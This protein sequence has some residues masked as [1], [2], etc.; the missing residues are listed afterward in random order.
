[1]LLPQAGFVI[2]ATFVENG[3]WLR[4][5]I[6]TRCEMTTSATRH[7]RNTSSGRC[8]SSRCRDWSRTSTYCYVPHP[9]VLEKLS[10]GEISTHFPALATF[11]Y[12][13]FNQA[14]AVVPG[15]GEMCGESRGH[16]R[17]SLLAA[18]KSYVHV[19]GRATCTRAKK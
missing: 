13:M 4:L 1:M 14:S 12:C 17:A 8:M 11:I 3:A 6:L 15:N 5:R 7:R 9:E 10:L 16:T 2:V 19:E 18:F